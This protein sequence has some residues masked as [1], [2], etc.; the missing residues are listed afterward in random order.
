M[1]RLMQPLS[2]HFLYCSPEAMNRELYRLSPNPRTDYDQN[3][4]K[5]KGERHGK[6]KTD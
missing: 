2:E 3:Q 1:N 5:T 4:K 6:S